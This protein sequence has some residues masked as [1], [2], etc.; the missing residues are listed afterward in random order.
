MT[1]EKNSDFEIEIKE[2][3]ENFLKDE[4][5]YLRLEEDFENGL[6]ILIS[7]YFKGYELAK[8]GISLLKVSPKCNEASYFSSIENHF[9]WM[10]GGEVMKKGGFLLHSSA[11][12]KDDK[13]SLFFGNSGDGKSTVAD[14]GKRRGGKILSDDL[15]IVYPEKDNYIA[16]GTAFYGALPQ[17]EKELNPYRIKSVYRLK[18]SEKTQIKSLSKAEALGYLLSHCQFVFSEKVRNEMLT[19]IVVKFIEKVP[20][21]ELYFR[22][23][24]S[25]WELI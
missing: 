25:F 22:R 19:P 17:N 7:T 3:E 11:I 16:Y 8:D 4:T 12:A 10:V 9:R 13:C 23:D 1:K 18:K 21:Y 20:C 15:I 2:K 14:F 24:D 6:K 5:G